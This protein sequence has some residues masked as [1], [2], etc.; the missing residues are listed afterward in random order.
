MSFQSLQL[1]LDLEALEALVDKDLFEE[2]SSLLYFLL[3]NAPGFLALL[4]RSF[5]TRQSEE[6]T[7][8]PLQNQASAPVAR[9]QDVRQA[10]HW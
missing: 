8:F 10:L 1:L 3:S 5:V 7:L 2:E 9:L 6:V 4:A